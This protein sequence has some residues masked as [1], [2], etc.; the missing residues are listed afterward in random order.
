MDKRLRIALILSWCIAVL[1]IISFGYFLTRDESHYPE[2][3]LYVN[4]ILRNGIGISII[5]IAFVVFL[6]LSIRGSLR[7]VFIWLGFICFFLYSYS[8]IFFSALGGQDILFE[9]CHGLIALL[10]L[11]VLFLAFRALDLKKIA[12]RFSEKTPLKIAILYFILSFATIYVS[13]YLLYRDYFRDRG[14]SEFI[15]FISDPKNVANLFI[16]GPLYLYMIV[17]IIKKRPLGYI[18]TPIL[19]VFNVIAVAYVV[20]GLF[21]TN[22]YL[23][24][25]LTLFLYGLGIALLVCFLRGFDEKS[26]QDRAAFKIEG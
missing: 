25:L 9:I 16:I 5:L 8:L 6:I 22:A 19:M 14:M 3:Y 10:S 24:F 13:T 4:D 23:V 2:H 18:L 1:Y 17:A 12:S 7:A 20:S 26:D 11:L 21:F 15:W